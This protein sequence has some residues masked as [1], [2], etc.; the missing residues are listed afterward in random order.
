M[1]LDVFIAT[2]GIALLSLVGAFL[3][4]H[5]R[6]LVGVERYV[7]P[8]AVGVFLALV[9]IELVPETLAESPEWGGFGI[10]LAFIGVYVLAHVLHVHLHNHQREHNEKQEAALLVLFGDALHNFADGVVIVGGFLISPEVGW[11]V[12]VAVAMHEIPQ[13]IVEFGILIKAGYSRTQAMLRNFI[14]ASTVVVGAGFTL[15]FAV[16]FTNLMWMVTA[17][18]AGNMLY[19]AAS[20]LL[21]RLHGARDTYNSFTSVVFSILLGFGIMT[22][23]IMWSHEN[24]MPEGV[25]DHDHAEEEELEHEEVIIMEDEH[26]HEH[27]D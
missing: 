10:G 2:L 22:G 23:A 12:T 21:P 26:D 16:Q 18:V 13:E 17:F 14:S 19:I 8:A 6:R 20:E 5:S 4:G 9:F 7:I 27:L 15:W 1:V 25:H 24:I 3:F 11:A